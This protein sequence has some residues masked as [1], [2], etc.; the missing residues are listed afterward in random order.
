MAVRLRP[1]TEQLHV[2]FCCSF[3]L[4]STASFST[5]TKDFRSSSPN[6]NQ[7]CLIRSRSSGPEVFH[8]F[9]LEIPDGRSGSG[10]EACSFFGF[11]FF[12]YFFDF[13]TEPFVD[14]C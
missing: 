6:P 2:C 12:L 5:L 3:I 8:I 11:F 7:N 10:S 13:G 4:R 9:S 1:H 14:R